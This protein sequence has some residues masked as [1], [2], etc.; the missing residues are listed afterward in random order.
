MI[1]ENIRPF[2]FILNNSKKRYVS[3]ANV[4]TL[5]F[6]LLG[7]SMMVIKKGIG[8]KLNLGNHLLKLVSMMWFVYL[9]QRFG[10]YLI[11]T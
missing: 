9:K 1:V 11:R 4:F 7:K 10:T 8:P 3:S 2:I 6:N 5:D